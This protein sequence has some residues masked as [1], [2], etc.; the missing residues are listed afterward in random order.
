[1]A[2][3]LYQQKQSC[4]PAPSATDAGVN[5][6]LALTPPMGWNSWNPFGK[7]VSEQVIRE[8]ADFFVS[9][10]MKDA[11]FTYIVIDDYLAGDKRYGYRSIEF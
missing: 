5:D 10:G 1:M 2:L 11:G 6:N 4:N 3:L 9:S 8:T 7:N